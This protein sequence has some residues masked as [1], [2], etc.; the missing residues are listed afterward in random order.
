L[1]FDPLTTIIDPFREIDFASFYLGAYYFIDGII[2]L[3]IFLGLGM[4]V[5]KKYYQQNAK[6]IVIG[7]GLAL[8]F[9]ATYFEYLT[10]FN[11]GQ[12][13]PIAAIIIL[14]IM[15]FL[16]YEFMHSFIN[17]VGA[18]ASIAMLL[19]AA[20][21]MSIFT[22]IY[23]WLVQNSPLGAA[24]VHLAV[25]FAF[26][27]L[28]I[29]LFRLFG[30]GQNAGTPGQQGPAGPQ[31]PPGN[32]GIPGQ[33]GGPGMPGQPGPIGPPGQGGGNPPNPPGQP[34]T[35]QIAVPGRNGQQFQQGQ[36]PHLEAVIRGGTSPYYF[37]WTINGQQA[38]QG[39]TNGHARTQINPLPPGRYHAIIEVTDTANHIAADQR[40]FVITGGNPL[41]V[42]VQ[43]ITH[44]V[45]P[46]G[47]VT[48]NLNIQGGQPPYTIQPIINP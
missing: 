20:M 13:Y 23:D 30:N 42:Q 34:L 45:A 41:Q 10:G 28:I 32:Q 15:I 25:V 5:F 3:M 11:L 1:A 22:G 48:V 4:F 38:G 8:T 24:L 39:Q 37:R 35:V 46:N 18:S 26:V 19:G 2:Y 36:L 43:P 40:D 16:I 21:L 31:G 12:L 14:F 29:R 17:D 27:L 44:P 9:A 33:G 47:N 6:P 7:V